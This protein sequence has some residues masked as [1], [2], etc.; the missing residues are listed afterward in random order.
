MI[1]VDKLYD[2]YCVISFKY[3]DGS[4]VQCVST[5]NLNLLESL[6]LSDIDGIIDLITYKIIPDN[7]FLDIDDIVIKEGKEIS[8]TSLDNLFQMSIKRRWEHAK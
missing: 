2:G 7:M 6:G 5:L 8:L 3:A 1:N 4:E